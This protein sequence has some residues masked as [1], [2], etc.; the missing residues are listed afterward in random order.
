[1]QGIYG[2]KMV[3]TC[4]T[5]E[6]LKKAKKSREEH[7]KIV[8]EARKGYL[9][10][11]QAALRE[12]LQELEAGKLKALSFRLKVPSD[13]TSEY[14]TVIQMLEMHQPDTI[15]LNADEVRH[16]IEDKWDWTD[17]FLTSN[18]LYSETAACKIGN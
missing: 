14:D 13:H 4:K 2:I 12:R 11:A 8:K 17:E 6:V 5:K 3:V 16:L 15:D 18:A 9:E 7:A 1:V 10:K